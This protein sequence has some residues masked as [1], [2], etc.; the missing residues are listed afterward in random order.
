M[1]LKKRYVIGTHVMWFEIEMYKDFLDG[2]V[3]L[4][5]SIDEDS[6][7]NVTVDI[8]FNMSE[9]IE[10][11]DTDKTTAQQLEYKFNEMTELFWMKWGVK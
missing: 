5:T 2:L 6:L 9:V 7:Y 11:I 1:E 4:L 10:K 3:N 8:C